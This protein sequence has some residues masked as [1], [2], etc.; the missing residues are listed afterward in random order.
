MDL[1]QAAHE[2]TDLS[3]NFWTQIL[4]MQ[5]PDEREGSS[6]SRIRAGARPAAWT[7]GGLHS[8]PTQDEWR[9]QPTLIRKMSHGWHRLLE[10]DGRQQTLRR[11]KTILADL[12]LLR[13]RQQ[14]VGALE[15]RWLCEENKWDKCGAADRAERNLKQLFIL[16]LLNGFWVFRYVKNFFIPDSII[17]VNVIC[18][19]Y[20]HHGYKIVVESVSSEVFLPRLCG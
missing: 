11:R 18:Y 16:Y 15:W 10:E 7:T 8:S 14:I 9:R 12:G 13:R 19:P 5:L 17:S 4:P 6:R 3:S 20:R 1:A 2:S